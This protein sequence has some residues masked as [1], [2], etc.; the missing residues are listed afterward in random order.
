MSK[1]EREGM[2]K[3]IIAECKGKEGATDADEAEVLARILPTTKTGKCIHACFAETVG[4]VQG[5][6]L[7]GD[8]M[9]EMAQKAFAGDDKAINVAKSVAADCGGIS[10]ADRCEMAGKLFTCSREVITKMGID[11]DSVI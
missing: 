1:D 2:A 4:F 8:G 6:K 7:N 3:Q 9:I 10:D 5:G 11:P